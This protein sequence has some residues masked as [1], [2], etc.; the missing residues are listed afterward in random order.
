VHSVSSRLRHLCELLGGTKDLGD[1]MCVMMNKCKCE[2]GVSYRLYIIGIK[3][4]LNMQIW[5]TGNW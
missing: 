2:M 3:T 1:R 4:V 5:K